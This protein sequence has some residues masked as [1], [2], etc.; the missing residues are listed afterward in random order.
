MR[1]I[2]LVILAVLIF[3]GLALYSIRIE[4]NRREDRRQQDHPVPAERRTQNRRK[5]SLVCHLGWVLRSLKS[6]FTR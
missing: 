5:K 3:F 1:T 6:K 2:V 4:E